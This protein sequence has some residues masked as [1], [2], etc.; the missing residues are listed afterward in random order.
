[1][2]KVNK[3]VSFFLVVF[4]VFSSYSVA[5][6]KS[7]V[8]NDKNFSP[9]ISKALMGFFTENKGQWNNEIIFVGKTPFG[10]IGF[11]RESIYYELIK[12][13]KVEEISNE[14]LNP[15]PKPEPE[16]EIERYVIKQSFKNSNLVSPEGSGLLPHLTNYFYGNDP[17]KW[18][19]GAKNY[20]KIV[21]KNIYDNIDL[22][23]FYNEDGLKYE[24]YLKKRAKV[25]DIKVAIEGA[26]I[27]KNDKTLELKT[28]LGSISDSG[29]FSFKPTSK[30]EIDTDF[31][32]YS[33]NVYGFDFNNYNICTNGDEVRED[34]VIDPLIYSTFLGGS[35]YEYGYDIA[36]DSSG[37]AYVTGYTGSSNFPT[38]PGAYETTYNSYDVFVTKFNSVGTALVYSTFLGG[39]SSD[40]GNGIAVDSSG[41]AYVTGY[42]YSSN[43]PTT[44][45]AWDR[46]YNSTEVFVTKFNSVGT[47]LVY[48]TFLGGSS[49]DYGNDIAVDSSGCAYVTGYTS[50]SNFP[51]TPGAY[52][53]TYNSSTDVFITEINV[54]G[55]S[56]NY[57]TYLG[58]SGP[59]FGNGIT[60]D[61]FGCAYVTG[62]T[63]SSNFPTTPGAW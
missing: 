58:G 26:D 39:S 17:S 59:D 51:T 57:S 20:S 35:S 13:H 12:F 1:M 11:G 53:T 44:P 27:I 37:C 46:T 24:F 2:K 52:D 18:I 33:E 63:Y 43:F 40:Y 60:I 3:L 15:K 45:G 42:T 19:K 47:A 8:N 34:I 5:G 25:S 10:R 55:T 21:Y 48:S 62:Y 29:L 9:D 61:S 31:E 6:A 36:V 16:P 23:Y 50:S 56:L 7:V 22:S 28:S 32:L 41:C 54:T 14:V 4:L 30:E 49:S 38:T